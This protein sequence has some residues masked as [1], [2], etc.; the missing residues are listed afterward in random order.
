MPNSHR[1]VSLL[2][3]VLCCLLSCQVVEALDRRVINGEDAAAAHCLLNHLPSILVGVTDL[4]KEF[5]GKRYN[6]EYMI[7]HCRYDPNVHADDVGLIRTAEAIQYG[8]F[9]KPITIDWRPVP[10]GSKLLT[11]GWGAISYVELS[12]ESSPVEEY[13]QKLQKIIMTAISL[14]ECQQYYSSDGTDGT[15]G[16]DVGGLC[17]FFA[18]GTCSGDSGG[19]LVLKDRLVGVVSYGLACGDNIPDVFASMWM[20]YDFIQTITRDCLYQDCVCREAM[21]FPHDKLFSESSK[22]DYFQSGKTTSNSK[23]KPV[24]RRR[25]LA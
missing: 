24:N 16:V 8:E 4:S 19:P 23:R 1:S 2:L 9:V 7:P 21:L 6:A 17:A 10:P 5:E 12:K 20:Y 22:E 18:G 11:T 3:V 15:D 25:V 13:P 14:E